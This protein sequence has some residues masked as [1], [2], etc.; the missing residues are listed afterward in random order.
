M[1]MRIPVLSQ[2]LHASMPVSTISHSCRVNS[3][4]RSIFDLLPNAIRYLNMSASHSLSRDDLTAFWGQDFLRTMRYFPKTLPS[5]YAL[6]VRHSEQDQIRM[7]VI[8]GSWITTCIGKSILEC[9]HTVIYSVI[10]H[11]KHHAMT[12]YLTLQNQKLLKKIESTYVTWVIRMNAENNITDIRNL[13]RR[14]LLI[15]QFSIISEAHRLE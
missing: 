10:R 9:S 14:E 15:R 11:G 1:T 4:G 2:T 7:P 5:I 6:V 3:F 13:L 8:G 12:V